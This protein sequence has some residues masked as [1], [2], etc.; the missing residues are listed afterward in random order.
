MPPGP[1]CLPVEGPRPVLPGPIS[2][3]Q[4]V[5]TVSVAS[6]NVHAGIDGWGQSFDYVAACADTDADVLVLQE[7]FAPDGGIALSEEVGKALGYS[8]HRVP[9]AFGWRLGPP[10]DP[11]STWGP[12]PSDHACAA[13]RLAGVSARRRVA[14]R[15]RQTQGR[16]SEGGMWGFAVL[17]R[18][19]VLDTREI[20]LGRLRRDSS[21]RKALLARIAT[22]SAPLTVIGTHM[23]HLSKGSPVQFR[24]LRRELEDV[25]GSAVLGGDMNLFGWPVVMLLPGWRRAVRGRT[26][27]AWRP[28]AQADHLLVRGID[29]RRA[30]VVRTGNSD[31]LPVRIELEVD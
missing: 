28:I 25:G 17:S 21:G 5:S 14:R 30:A 12:R 20:D 2:V 27:P 24:K 19:S 22:G 26:W 3:V 9:L 16:S 11:P 31:H 8:V 23:S 13:L 18:L 7:D 10:A 4:I 29:V 15:L 6:F 1:P